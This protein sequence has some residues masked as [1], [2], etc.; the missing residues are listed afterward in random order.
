MQ[1]NKDESQ[2]QKRLKRAVVPRRVLCAYGKRRQ[3]R[4]ILTDLCF[5]PKYIRTKLKVM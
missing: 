4:S 1:R 5:I 2:A 3:D